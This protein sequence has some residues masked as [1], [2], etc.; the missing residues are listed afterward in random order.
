MHASDDIKKLGTILSVWAHPDDETFA[1]AGL[2]ATAVQNGQTVVCVTAT[3]GEAGV[4]DEKKWPARQLGDIRAKELAA[5]LK[6]LGI[7]QHEWL[8]YRDGACQAAPEQAVVAK[9][10]ALLHTHKPDTVITFGPDGLTGHPDHC[11]VSGWV[12]KAVTA[13]AADIRVLHVVNAPGHYEQYL[14]QMDKRLDIFYNID[15]PALL[16][17]EACALYYELPDEMC[18]CKCAALKA[19]PSQTAGMFAAFDEDFLQKAFGVEAFRRARY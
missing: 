16:E 9:I 2:L 3:K 15:K 8:G 1:A 12:D 6:I 11:C 7:R 13:A 18:R 4:Q 19:M 10:A 5:A 14:K 17:P